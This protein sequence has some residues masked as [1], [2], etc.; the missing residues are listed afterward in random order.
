MQTELQTACYEPSYCV[1]PVGP[2]LLLLCCWAA[3]PPTNGAPQPQLQQLSLS[4]AHID[5][6]M[7]ESLAMAAGGP[8]RYATESSSFSKRLQPG[9]HACGVQAAYLLKTEVLALL[10]LL[11]HALQRG[12]QSLQ[13]ARL[14]RDVPHRILWQQK[15]A[16]SA[17][18]VS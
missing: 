8:L 5:R 3:T 7:L 4:T 14:L 18:E 12:R 10:G 9:L 17:S 1:A 2:Q 11:N 13:Q 15:P 6:F 16:M